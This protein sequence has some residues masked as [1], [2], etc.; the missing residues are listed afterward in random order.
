MPLIPPSAPIASAYNRPPESHSPRTFTVDGD[1]RLE[2][3]LRSV[4][5]VILNGLKRIVPL[6]RLQAIWLGGGYGRGEGGVLR[7]TA[8]DRPYNDLEFYVYLAGN[9]FANRRNFGPT[10][11]E[12]AE[13]MTALAEVEVEFHIISIAELRRPTP[14]MFY[15]DLV[16]GHRQ[17]W[18]DKNLLTECA[19]HCDARKLPLIEATRLLM[20][21]GTGLLLAQDRLSRSVLSAADIDFV[22]RNIAKAQ[23]ALG[24][25]V[26]TAFG[27]YHWSCRER[28][29]RLLKLTAAKSPWYNELCEH[30]ATGVAFKLHPRCDSISVEELRGE[31]RRVTALMLPVWLWL[32]SRRLGL[33][34]NTAHDYVMSSKSK[35]PESNPWRNRL[36]NARIFGWRALVS[37]RGGR[38]PRERV[39]TALA[40]LLWDHKNSERLRRVL[41]GPSQPPKGSGTVLEC[42]LRLW[43]RVR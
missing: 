30:H 7:T 18:G 37:P 28:H 38:H 31:H 1:E 17:L 3:H 36:L 5:A 14:N 23:L 22:R 12:F 41:L 4:C 25:A 34:F 40:I 35:C 21:R 24:D 10:L 39:F 11:H 43:E 26:L 6:E 19:H 16:C 13:K 2:A 27:E 20:N 8:G 29:Q 42:Y 9:R 33:N 32:E 15:Y